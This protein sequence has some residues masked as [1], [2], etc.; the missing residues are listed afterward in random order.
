MQGRID[1]QFAQPCWS[2]GQRP[3]PVLAHVAQDGE[4]LLTQTSDRGLRTNV[5]NLLGGA[6][7][8]LIAAVVSDL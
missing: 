1:R 6:A 8:P 5:G 4:L 7:S 2:P 3:S